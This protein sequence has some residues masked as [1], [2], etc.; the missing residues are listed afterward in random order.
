MS[1]PLASVGFAASAALGWGTSDF[2]GGYTARRVNAF[3]LTTIA[4]ASGT[5]FM[6]VLALARR[7]QLPSA[8]N[9]AWAIAAGLS[10]GAALAVFYRALSSGKM[11]LAAPVSAVVAAA[12]PTLFGILTEGAPGAFKVA[13]F[14]LAGTGIWL[15]SRPDE[16]GHPREVGSAALAAIGFAGYF[17]FIKQAGTG[18]SVFW[19]AGIARFASFVLTLTIVVVAGQGRP[20]SIA[21]PGRTG[22]SARP[23]DACTTAFGVLA[24]FMDICGSALFIRASQLGRLDVAVVLSSFYPAVTVL[25]ARVFL[26]EYFTRWTAVGM[27]A[28]LA[29]VPMIA[30]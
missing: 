16:K 21:G 2:I 8:H 29:A 20:A 10:G 28:V 15:V 1:A 27:L 23:I 11:G 17:L 9:W 7:A 22:V 3:L 25:L 6:L 30:A 13:G 18:S 4:H 5:A 14:V 19:I 26:H 12:I 24:G